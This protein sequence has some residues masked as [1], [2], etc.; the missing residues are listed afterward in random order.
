MK[1]IIEDIMNRLTSI[2]QAAFVGVLIVTMSVA[3]SAQSSTATTQGS[4]AGQFQKVGAA[5]GEFLR[6]VPGARA[7]GM[8]GAFSG[9]A[10][11]L[12]A[13]GYNV[14]GIVDIQGYTGNVSYAQ[15]FGGYSHN[16]LG[17][18]IPVDNKYRFGISVTDFTSGEIERTTIEDENRLGLT[19]SIN[20]FALT[21]SFGAFLTDQFSFGI[22]AKYVQN[23][24]ASMSASGVFVDMGTLYRFGGYRIGF[25]MN[26]LGA[27]M[28]FSGQDLN[29]KTDLISQL[30]YQKLDASLLSN[31]FNVPIVFNAGIAC[32]VL[33]EW[34]GMYES[35][36]DLGASQSR[37]HRLVLA[38]DFSTLS[39]VSQQ[40]AIG[41]EYVWDDILALRAGYRMGSDQFNFSGGVGVHYI[42]AGF[43]ATVDYAMQPTS[44]LGMINRISVSLR[45][46]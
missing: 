6:I 24:I 20:D 38:A 36:Q 33:S 15:W 4:S 2:V 35:T 25:S 19:Y 11:D 18:V 5:G 9:V 31:P 28:Q 13:I 27:Q 26:N 30:Q 23:S 41:A 43:D 1:F 21:A 45:A 40:A 12:S 44:D 42:L 8:A 16:Y 3:T 7:T 29:Q 37:E 14:A 17:V 34:F 32:E 46:N 22:N 39:D 10:N